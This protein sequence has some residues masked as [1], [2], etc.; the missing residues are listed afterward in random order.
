MWARYS[1]PINDFKDMKDVQQKYFVSVVT[2]SGEQ[3]HALAGVVSNQLS[4]RMQDRAT[5]EARH[6]LEDELRKHE[7]MS[8]RS[9]QERL[10]GTEDFIFEPDSAIRTEFWSIFTTLE[11]QSLKG[12]AQSIFRGVGSHQISLLR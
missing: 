8:R 1:K 3:D 6:A 10:E 4:Q 9:I 7:Q 5:R 2:D 12:T 11:D